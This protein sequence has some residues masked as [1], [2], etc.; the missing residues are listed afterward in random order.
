MR[1]D[2]P[3]ISRVRNVSPAGSSPFRRR[4]GGMAARGAGAAGRPRTAHVCS[5]RSTKTIPRRSHLRVHSSACGLGLER[6]P[7]RADGPSI[8]RRCHQSDASTRRPAGDADDSNCLCGPNPVAAS[9][10]DSTGRVGRP[11][12]ARS[13]RELCRVHRHLSHFPQVELRKPWEASALSGDPGTRRIWR[14]NEA[15]PA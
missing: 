8:H 4:G 15:G 1:Q 3:R 14:G 5:R 12:F 7:Q 13:S 9:S 2:N 6:W 10:R 11:I